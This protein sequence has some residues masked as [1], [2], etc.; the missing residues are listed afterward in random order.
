MHKEV[1]EQ[2]VAGVKGTARFVGGDA[3]TMG[4]QREG[5]KT[6]GEEREGAK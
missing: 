6:M 1:V 5:A 3:K 4:E 2:C